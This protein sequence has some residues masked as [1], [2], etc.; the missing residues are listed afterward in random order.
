MDN[1]H[2]PKVYTGME[3]DPE[4]LSDL[5]GIWATDEV[6]ETKPKKAPSKKAKA[7]DDDVYMDLELDLFEGAFLNSAALATQVAALYASDDSESSWD[8]V[9]ALAETLKGLQVK[10]PEQDRPRWIPKVGLHPESQVRSKG[11]TGILRLQ[12][13]AAKRFH[14]ETENP[15]L[16]ETHTIKDCVCLQATEKAVNVKMPD[17]EEAWFPRTQLAK[18]NEILDDADQGTLVVTAWIAKQKGLIK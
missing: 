18:G 5:D 15:P 14:E 3:N 9:T 17:G 4:D 7:M 12:D 1:R 6:V 8:G 2:P 13:W 10:M 11:D 16:E